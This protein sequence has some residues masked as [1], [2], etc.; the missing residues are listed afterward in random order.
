MEGDLRCHNVSLIFTQAI[1]VIPRITK[2]LI[3]Q[4]I[5]GRYS[6]G[7]WLSKH[8]CYLSACGFS[9]QQMQDKAI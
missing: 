4:K 1:S 8:V 7:F 9:P 5:K 2:T 6:D 3:S